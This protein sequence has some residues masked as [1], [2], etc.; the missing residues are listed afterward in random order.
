VQIQFCGSVPLN[1]T[2]RIVT[3]K[4][5][6]RGAVDRLAD[7]AAIKLSMKLTGTFV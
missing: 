4:R 3:E 1:C 6:D 7:T 2:P 5:V